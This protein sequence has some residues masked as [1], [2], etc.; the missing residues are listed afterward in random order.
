MNQTMNGSFSQNQ[1]QS[2]AK[3]RDFDD[4][5]SM[6]DPVMPLTKMTSKLERK[7]TFKPE[8]P[9]LGSSEINTRLKEHPINKNEILDYM[10]RLQK[11]GKK[12]DERTYEKLTNTQGF[13]EIQQEIKT[14]R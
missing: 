3:N 1:F 14:H 2:K 5:Q 12:I 13:K 7:A 6:D 10:V 8:V 11:Q 4:I 9:K